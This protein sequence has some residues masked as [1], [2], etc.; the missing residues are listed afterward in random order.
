[1]F[2][3]QIE[4]TT[5]SP[6]NDT[7]N[8]RVTQANRLPDDPV[9]VI[10]PSRGWSAIDFPEMWRYKELLYFL[11]WRDVAVRYKQTVLGAAWAVLQPLAT[12]VIFTLLF[13]RLAK[14]PS[15]GV[16]YPIFAY[17][18]LLPW[19]FFS[20]AVTNSG[21][22]LV[23]SQNLITKIYFPRMF[24]P[25]AAIGAG[26]VDFAIAASVLGCLMVYYGIQLTWSFL[27]VP[28]L[29]IQ[30]TALAT[31][32]GLLLSALNVKYRDVRYVVPFALQFWMFASPVIY[33]ISFVPE[34]YRSLVLLNPLSGLIDGYRAALF[35]NPLDPKSLL[36]SAMLTLL[37]LVVSLYSF[38][39]MER[40]FADVV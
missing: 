12:M 9:L 6:V 1:M 38:R 27:L 29:V 37:V 14:I 2:E 10:R 18:G 32:V 11:T 16:P 33:P 13:G 20:N 21:N 30:T 31:G 35:G 24:I 34:E 19:M 8:I 39:R 23:G 17:A 3:A 15:D 28:L 36:I 7:A 25:M 5:T 22:S 26:L 40:Q 4:L